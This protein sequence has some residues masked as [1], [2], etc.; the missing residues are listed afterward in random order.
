[1]GTHTW[2]DSCGVGRIALKIIFYGKLSERLGSEIEVEPPAGT[3][4]VT[5]LRDV[6]AGMFPDVAGDLKERS[7]ACIADSIVCEAHQLHGT[8]TVEF[9]P[10]LSGG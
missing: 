5:Q 6:L 7:R 2:F 9:L 10:P 4:T 1:M 8:E 3:D